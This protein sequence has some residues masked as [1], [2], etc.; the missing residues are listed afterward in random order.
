MIILVACALLRLRLRQLERRMT[1]LRFDTA[2]SAEI[3]RVRTA[4][5]VL[6]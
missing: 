2:L 5:E 1:P 3:D 6:R 4:L